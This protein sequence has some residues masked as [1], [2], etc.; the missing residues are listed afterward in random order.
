MAQRYPQV[1][2]IGCEPF[3]NGIAMLLGRLRETPAPNLAIHPGDARDLLDVLPP[4]CLERVF[5]LYPDPWPKARHHRR[6]FVTPEHLGPSPAPA[7]RGPSSASPPTSPT[8][9]ARRWRK[10]RA[11]V[12]LQA[13]RAEPWDDW[14]RTRY[15]H[16]RPVPDLAAARLG[17]RRAD[18]WCYYFFRDPETRHARTARG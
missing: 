12:H 4:G 6:R 8:T 11:R 14:V 1:R 10:C 9:S 17:R 13:D 5:L 18:V 7:R 15:D 16:A 3:V 2:L